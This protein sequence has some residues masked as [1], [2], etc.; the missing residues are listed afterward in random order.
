MDIHSYDEET[1]SRLRGIAH[2]WLGNSCNLCTESLLR[3]EGDE[4]PNKEESKRLTKLLFHGT[5]SNE[6]DPYDSE[7]SLCDF[8]RHLRLNHLLK[9]LK[10]GKLRC[11]IRFCES[12]DIEKRQSCPFCHLLIRSAMPYEFFSGMATRSDFEGGFLEMIVQ[13]GGSIYMKFQYPDLGWM[14]ARRIYYGSTE[15]LEPLCTGYTELYVDPV[16]LP[17]HL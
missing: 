15:G 8:C 16:P 9:C 17:M 2:K 4:T 14:G 3:F 5:C 13:G 10:D 6:K 7:E 1:L 12:E 11:S